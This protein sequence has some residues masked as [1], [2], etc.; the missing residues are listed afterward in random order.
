[1]SVSQGGTCIPSCYVVPGKPAAIG[2]CSRLLQLAGASSEL[3][4]GVWPQVVQA[5]WLP[6]ELETSHCNLLFQCIYCFC[7]RKYLC[8]ICE[9]VIF[10]CV[11]W[12]HNRTIIFV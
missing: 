7:D 12:S 2:K 1:M 11:H 3:G 8:L 5:T 9:Y 4:A 6:F 10:S